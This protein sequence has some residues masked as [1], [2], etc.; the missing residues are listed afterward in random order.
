M[1]IFKGRQRGS[2]LTF[3]IIAIVLIAATIGTIV[4]VQQRGEQARQNEATKIADQIAEQNADNA[5]KAADEAAKS[6]ETAT[7]TSTQ[8]NSTTLPETGMET[9]VA[10]ILA[11][12]TLTAVVFSYIASRRGLKRSL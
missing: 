5:K 6:G 1:S 7:T 11:V 4:L 8:N 3:I 9:D 12:G 10:R 2:V